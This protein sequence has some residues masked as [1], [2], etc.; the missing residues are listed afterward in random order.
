MNAEVVKAM[1]KKSNEETIFAKVR[2]WWRKNDYKVYRVIFFPLWFAQCGIDKYN[3]RANERNAWNEERANKILNYSIPRCAKWNEEDKCFYFFDNGCGWS[4]CC[5][6]KY[7][8]RKDRRFWKVNSGLYGG[9]IRHYLIKNFELEGFTKE[10]VDTSD[11]WTEIEFKLN[12][13]K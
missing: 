9:E 2:S 7:L 1:N 8:N 12:E 6:K 11:G 10:I 5:A 3:K 13:E 4:M